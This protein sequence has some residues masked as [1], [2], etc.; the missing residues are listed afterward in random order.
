MIYSLLS[1]LGFSIS[2]IF[3]KKGLPED[4]SRPSFVEVQL[5]TLLATV[6]FI[7]LGSLLAL[8][9]GY[10]LV[11]EIRSLPGI[12]LFLLVLD[13][14]FGAVIGLFLT[15]VAIS[16]IGPS[17]TSSL[18]AS[19]PLFATLFAVVFLNEKLDV[20]GIISILLLICGIALI[21]YKKNNSSDGQPSVKNRHA[22]SGIALLSALSYSI[23][24]VARGGALK[25][26]ATPA[27]TLTIG[28]LSAAIIIAAIYLYQKRD[29]GA[30]KN[31]LTVSSKTLYSFG[32][33]GI[34][35]MAAGYLFAIALTSIPVWMAISIRN[36]QPLMTIIIG[37]LF[38]KES[39]TINYKLILG[40]LMVM[41]G[42]WLTTFY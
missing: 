20:T 36:T 30:I 9:L 28:F 21:C 17:R 26:G 25:H 7:V 31:L 6:I 2:F 37:W 10:H 1:A 14:L 34:S 35:N 3:I 38:L 18:R 42:I 33:A 29:L 32:A 13:G 19:N 16:K 8:P 39:E 11:N 22:G 12:A 27:A 40:T 41:T 15:N 4:G 23:S 5:I 24:Q